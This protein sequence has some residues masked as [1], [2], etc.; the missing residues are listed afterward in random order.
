MEF[1]SGVDAP[2]PQI[3]LEIFDTP[4][5]LFPIYAERIKMPKRGVN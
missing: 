1:H 2:H 3:F 5:E 4:S